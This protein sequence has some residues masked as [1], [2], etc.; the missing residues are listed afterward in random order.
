VS[1][2]VARLHLRWDLPQCFAILSAGAPA[3]RIRL[4]VG[5]V[6]RPYRLELRGES[7]VENVN[8]A[9]GRT[10]SGVVK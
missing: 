10:V 2:G 1:N 8:R 7:L 9:C 4:V 6:R 3:L 5:D